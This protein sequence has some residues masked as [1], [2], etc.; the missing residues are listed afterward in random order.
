MMDN[1]AVCMSEGHAAAAVAATMQECCLVLSQAGRPPEPPPH[2]TRWSCSAHVSGMAHV[3]VCH[4]TQVG[5]LLLLLFL[6]GSV[7]NNVIGLSY[8][9]GIR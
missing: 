3:T 9:E 5:W 8:P 2:E 6:R 1:T 4:M 7:I